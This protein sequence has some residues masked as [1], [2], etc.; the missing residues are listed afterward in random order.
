MP[1]SKVTVMKTFIS[2]LLALKE[3]ICFQTKQIYS[4]KMTP[5]ILKVSDV[6]EATFCLKIGLLEKKRQHFQVYPFT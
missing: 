5:I 3:R 2:L 4:L 6:W 1:V